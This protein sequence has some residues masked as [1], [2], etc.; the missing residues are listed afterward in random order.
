MGVLMMVMG[1]CP[2][3]TVA[4]DA[5]KDSA[6]V[7]SGFIYETASFPQCHASTIAET[8]TGMIAAWFGGTEEKAPDV[9]IWVSRL[10]EGSWSPPIEVAN[11]IQHATLRWPCWNPVLYQAAGGPLVLFYKVGPSPSTW[12]GMRME[13]KDG[14]VT[15]S[16]SQR[17]PDKIFGP[18]KNKPITLASGE[19]L[20][21][22]SDETSQAPS[23]W[24]VHF[25]RT[26]DLGLTWS[27]TEPLNDGITVAAIQ[28]SILQHGDGRLQ[29]VGRSR[30]GKI[31]TIQSEDQGKTWAEMSFLDLPNN[32]SG[33]DAVTLKDG[34]HL[35]VYNHTTKGRSPLNV[36]IS[37]DGQA[38]E[39][40]LVLEDQP[41]EYS[42]PAVMQSSDGLVHITYT[43]KR[44]RVKH[45]VVDPAKMQLK[46]IVNA[47]WPS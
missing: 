25:E 18:I 4:E 5:G 38:W 28:P 19:M 7:A 47:K 1:S 30:Q 10:I 32:N 11:G 9:G 22:T 23:R 37:M 27:R 6:V 24:T 21:P 26:G 17:L 33:T 13:S 39:A 46:P 14:G 42:Y 44:Q 40:A 20:C 12:W 36:S 16:R 31:F 35:L 41:G 45:V 2:T 3:T 15:W 34:R 43:W 29:A 8:P